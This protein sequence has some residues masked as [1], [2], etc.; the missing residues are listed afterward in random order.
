MALRQRNVTVV[1]NSS[2]LIQLFE[3]PNGAKF[4]V[5]TTSNGEVSQTGEAIEEH[6]WFP[7]FAWKIALCPHCGMHLGW[8]FYAV[9]KEYS[10]K[11]DGFSF[12]GVILSNILYS[13]YPDSILFTPKAYQ[14]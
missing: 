5:I 8:T 14:S 3:N 13:K 7:G 1:G 6:S 9:D 4:E 10:E 11:S 12:L 2:T